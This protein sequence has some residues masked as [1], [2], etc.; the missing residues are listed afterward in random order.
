MATS[1]GTLRLEKCDHVAV[2]FFDR[3]GS[4]VPCKLLFS[5]GVSPH[6]ETDATP[7]H[8]HRILES[9]RILTGENL[10]PSN[11]SIDVDARALFSA[12]FVVVAHGTEVDPVLYYGNQAALRLWEMEWGEFT[13]TPSRFTAEAPEREERARLLAEVTA[14]GFI[15][16]YSGIRIS[17][18]G[19]R[20]RIR[21]ATVW[22]VFDADGS[23]CGQAATFAA[24]ELI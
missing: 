1:H 17:K 18:T 8:A 11:G 16:N 13:R 10:L 15:R 7:L 21:G 20:F 4:S 5:F 14:H 3:A 12:P 9:H 6:S 2:P 23:L 19:V 22:N 24:W